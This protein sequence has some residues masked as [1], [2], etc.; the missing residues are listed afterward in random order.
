MPQLP[1]SEVARRI[2]I[3]A[4]AI[5]Y[6]EQIGLL[7]PPHRIG[8]QRRYDSTG[9]YRLAV[10]QKARQLGF[11]L[12]EIRQL[13]LGFREGPPTRTAARWRELSKRKLAE[14]NE[15]SQ[16][17]KTMQRLLQ[18]MIRLCPLQDS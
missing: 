16:D 7:P 10:V 1:I 6:Y 18:R 9:I 13:F 4:S 5:R 2:G 8:G 3:Q 14:L 12:E 15:L 11:T 17:V